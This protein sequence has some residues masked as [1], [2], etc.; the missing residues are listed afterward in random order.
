MRIPTWQESPARQISMRCPACRQIGTFDSSGKHDFIVFGE[1]NVTNWQVGSR[2]CPN[3]SCYAHVFTVWSPLSKELATSY[4]PESIDFD[5][6]NLPK[7]VLDSLDEAVR[8]HAAQSYRAAALMVRRTLEDLCAD[9]GADG[10]NL[11]ARLNSL[12]GRIAVAAA[13]VEGLD[14]LRLL[15][16]D[17]AHIELKDFDQVGRSEAEL[18]IEI[19]KELL[20]GVYQYDDL[21]ARLDALKRPK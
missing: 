2:R 3:P 14:N 15:G 6:T 18:A 7:A 12:S 21:V 10:V 13:L 11:K 8:C 9:R 20:K 5:A 16:N 19:V 17:A 1:D 4:P